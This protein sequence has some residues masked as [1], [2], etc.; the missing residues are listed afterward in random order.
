MRFVLVASSLIFRVT[1]DCAPVAGQMVL[2]MQ[3]N[4]LGTGSGLAC[5]VPCSVVNGVMCGF[6]SGWNCLLQDTSP[7]KAPFCAQT[8][9]S[10]SD[11]ASG[12]SCN[13]GAKPLTMASL[14]ICM[15]SPDPTV[16]AVQTANVMPVVDQ[17]RFSPIITASG[18]QPNT[19]FE[20]LT[21]NLADLLNQLSNENNLGSNPTMMA[22]RVSLAALIKLHPEA[23]A[24]E[25]PNAIL[26]DNDV[27]SYVEYAVDTSLHNILHPIYSIREGGRGAIWDLQH[28]FSYRSCF[29]WLRG[30]LILF[31]IYSLVGCW[32]KATYEKAE[33]INRLPHLAFWLDFPQLVIDGVNFTVAKLVGGGTA[34]LNF[35][36]S[37]RDSKYLSA[38]DSFANFEPIN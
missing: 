35:I 26:L 20:F 30:L 14:G 34:G 17:Q 11:C 3:V 5:A 12:S 4:Q 2:R 21:K 32:Y 18:M 27:Q 9:S 7:A 25:N 31:V 10:N 36:A 16:T 13:L 19:Q 24:K 37:A 22:L 29:I 28:P 23:K 1:G 8:C 38:R 15:T 6:T 33:G